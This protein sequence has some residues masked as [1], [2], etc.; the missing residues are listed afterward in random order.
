MITGKPPWTIKQEKKWRM[1]IIGRKYQ[2]P[3]PITADDITCPKMKVRKFTS[4]KAYAKMIKTL[5]EMESKLVE[6]RLAE[7]FN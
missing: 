6:Y 7:L 5:R 4:K 3:I 2:K 1:E